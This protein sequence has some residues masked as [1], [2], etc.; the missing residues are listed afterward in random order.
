M[1]VDRGTFAGLLLD[2]LGAPRTDSNVAFLVAWM[3]REGTSAAF[4][5]L[6][7]TLPWPGSTD[8]NSVG[9]RNY[10]TLAAGVAA[11]AQTLTSGY[12]AIVGDLRAGD[13]ARAGQEHAELRKWSGGGYD[14]IG[15]SGG[16]G[17]VGGN[18]GVSTEGFLGDVAHAVGAFL[19]DALAL[20]GLGL[21]GGQ[22]AAAPWLAELQQDAFRLDPTKVL[23]PELLAQGVL[24]NLIDANEAADDAAGSG[25]RR[26]RFDAMVAIAGNPPGPFEI[27][28]MLN[29]GIVDPP[30]AEQGLRESYLRNEWVP[31]LMQ[32][33][34][35]IMSTPEAV[36]AAVQNHISY[37]LARDAAELNGTPGDLF[38]VLYQTA[39]NPPGPTETLNMMV[40]GIFTEADAVQALRESRLKDKYIPQFLQLARRRIPLRTITSLL[41]NGAI[42]DAQA[43]EDLKALG[44]SDADAAA[45]VAGH[46]KPPTAPHREL[47]VAQIR[48][49][50]SQRMISREEAAADLVALGYTLQAA[51]E[52][53]SLADTADARSLR[54]SAITKVRGAYDRRKITR[55]EASTDLDRI[56]VPGATRD[57]MLN[58]WDIER[59]A[60]TVELSATDICGAGHKGV[61]DRAEVLA[62]LEAIGYSPDDALVFA[63][64]HNGIPVPQTGG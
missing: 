27:L 29:R 51:N 1:A 10:P 28:R 62:R 21:G 40:R 41:N 48:D 17:N 31:M 45:I 18:P 55:A 49:L 9:V 53:L 33:R 47:S 20:I 58:L 6:A 57:D 46:K 56:G 34:H 8:F 50:Y 61:F 26:S 23:P 12:P 3:G 38:D 24:K 44:Y 19:I 32:L 25:I 7:T 64:V 37:G 16:A 13:G 4:N 14:S 63:Y 22:A 43:I 2:A 11:T 52:V 59:E 30:T 35:D 5:P 39:G 15:G 54:R 42:T 60:V 36:E